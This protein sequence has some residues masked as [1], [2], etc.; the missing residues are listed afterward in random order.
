M[1]SVKRD[2]SPTPAGH[3]LLRK[4]VFKSPFAAGNEEVRVRREPTMM[5]EEDQLVA[6][7]DNDN[8]RYTLVL[9][10][11]ETVIYAREG[12]LYAR[13]Y[14]NELLD[15]IKRNFEVIVWTAGEREYAKSIM[16]EINVD[17]TVR[18]LIYRHEVWFS[19]D[20]YTKDLK[21]LGRDIDYVVIIENTPECVRSNPQNGIIVDDFRVYSKLPLPQGDTEA[22]VLRR[23]KRQPKAKV[24]RPATDRTLL[25]LKELLG[26]LV[27][28]GEPVPR[29]LANC[30]LL[31]EQT[32]VGFDGHEIQIYHLGR[33]RKRGAPR[34]SS[35]A[36]K[37]VKEFHAC[38]S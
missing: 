5:R 18:H 33:R 27:K 32:A 26:A 25:L 30:P 11:D 7:A 34:L 38:L 22:K 2:L 14:L 10:L 13:P 29:F 35:P 23:N 24:R 4:N 17:N 12:P 37:R 20:D 31:T 8:K 6:P 1:K 36:P 19:F 3:K 16:E 21:R 28:S 15:F 9:D